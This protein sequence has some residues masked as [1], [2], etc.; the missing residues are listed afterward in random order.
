[1]DPAEAR[2]RADLAA[3]RLAEDPRVR[4]VYL[5]GSAA[6][7]DAT[8]AR[9]VDLAVATEPRMGTLALLDFHPAVTKVA[10][11]AVDLVSFHDAGAVLGK[12]IVD[13]G[14]CLF[15][16]T[17]D[18][19]VEVVTRARMRYLDFKPF[20]AVQQQAIAGRRAERLARL[21]HQSPSAET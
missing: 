6:D 4:V 16:R 20:L 2:R 8:R 12:E 17:P 18:D 5:F 10:G 15:T 14:R 7:A 9:D 1:M 3:A 21:A 19:E 11:G 13:H